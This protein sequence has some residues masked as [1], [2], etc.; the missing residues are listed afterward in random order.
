MRQIDRSGVRA[1]RL[2]SDSFIVR[3]R[4]PIDASANLNP[5]AGGQRNPAA[6]IHNVGAS[7]A[8]RSYAIASRRGPDASQRMS[9]AR[10][11]RGGYVTKYK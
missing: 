5:P 7:V 1:K 10:R 4:R 2:V 11:L 8:D 3:L 9:Y 6:P